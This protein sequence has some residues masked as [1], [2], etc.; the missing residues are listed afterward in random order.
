MNENEQSLGYVADMLNALACIDRFI[1]N[2]SYEAF[3]HDDKTLFALTHAVGIIGQAAQQIPPALQQEYPAIP[4]RQMANMP[5][6]LAYDY[7]GISPMVLWQTAR[8][9]LPALAPALNT[10]RIQVQ[11]NKG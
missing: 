6:K 3:R 9:E 5:D 11:Q 4:W 2:M 1:E 8:V 10:M 7:I